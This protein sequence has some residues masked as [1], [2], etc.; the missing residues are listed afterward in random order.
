[1]S[2]NYLEKSKFHLY[3]SKYQPKVPNILK[4][5]HLAPVTKEAAILPEIAAIFPHTQ[6]FGVK[7]V[8]F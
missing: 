2:S 4:K 1:M 3:R 7:S 8:K 6:K 5:P